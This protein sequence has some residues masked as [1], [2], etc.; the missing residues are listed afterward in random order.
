MVRSVFAAIRSGLQ[1]DACCKLQS[2]AC[3]E[4]MPAASKSA[5]CKVVAAVHCFV[6]QAWCS[7]LAC[8]VEGECLVS[9]FVGS[10]ATY[11][12]GLAS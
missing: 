4:L 3:C 10:A 5:C 6:V 11:S 1:A 8:S 2:Q 7:V 9:V 12:N